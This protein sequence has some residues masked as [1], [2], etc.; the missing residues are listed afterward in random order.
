MTA[1]GWL[2]ALAAAGLFYGGFGAFVLGVTIDVMLLLG[3]AT[4]LVT[5]FLSARPRSSPSAA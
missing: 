5:T 3:A 2:R 4:L 1:R